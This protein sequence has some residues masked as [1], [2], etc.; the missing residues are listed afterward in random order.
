M[1]H[2]CQSIYARGGV[3][4]TAIYGCRDI[5]ANMDK[6]Y[7]NTC[8]SPFASIRSSDRSQPVGRRSHTFIGV[9]VA[10]KLPKSPLFLHPKALSQGLQGLPTRQQHDGWR[11]RQ[12]SSFQALDR[13]SVGPSLG[14]CSLSP[15]SPST[16]PTSALVARAQGG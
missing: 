14:P 6:Y 7:T 2:V 10:A 4:V 12:R 11:F 1:Y 9:F 13:P 3:H 15:G 5:P 8:I 16:H